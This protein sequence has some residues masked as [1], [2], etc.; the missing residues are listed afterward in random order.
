MQR[1]FV[2]DPERNLCIDRNPAA[3]VYPFCIKMHIVFKTTKG[4]N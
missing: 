2:R 4:K 1:L 3:K